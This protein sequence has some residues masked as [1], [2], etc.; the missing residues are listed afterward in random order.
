MSGGWPLARP[1]PPLTLDRLHRRLGDST[2]LGAPPPSSAPG[3]RRGQCASGAAGE[4]RH[5][6]RTCYLPTTSTS[7]PPMLPHIHLDTFTFRYGF[8]KF[9]SMEKNIKFIQIVNSGKIWQYL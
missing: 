9:S 1:A 2:M 3:Q 6:Y 4:K 7:T 5:L 8:S